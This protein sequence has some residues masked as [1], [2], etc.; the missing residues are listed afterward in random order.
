MDSPENTRKPTATGRAGDAAGDPFDPAGY[1]RAA[2]GAPV[3]LW[4]SGQDWTQ[5][6]LNRYARQRFLDAGAAEQWTW[7]EAVQQGSAARVGRQIEDAYQAGEPFCLLYTAELGGTRFV[8]AD[9]GEPRRDSAGKLAGYAGSWAVVDEP[10]RPAADD[11]SA[12]SLV[13]LLGLR[14]D[15]ASYGELITD[16]NGQV[17]AASQVMERLLGYTEQELA[18]RTLI[19]LAHAQ[20]RHSP[21]APIGPLTSRACERR[22]LKKDGGVLWS[23]TSVETIQDA[24]GQLCGYRVE[25]HDVSAEKQTER[26][27]LDS[28]QR[29]T[30]AQRAGGAGVFEWLILENRVYWSPELEELYGI[31]P[32]R[33][34]GTFDDWAKRVLPEDSEKIRQNVAEW[35]QQRRE[36][37]AYEFR[38][39]LPDGSHR[40]M[41]G[42]ARF[43][44]RE[45]GT[46]ERMIGVNVRMDLLKSVQQALEE[47]E[48][49]FR[50]LADHMSQLAWMA[51]S[52]G[53]IFWYNR[54]WYEYTGT[55]LEEMQ[56]WGWKKV[57]HPDHVDRVAEKIQKC[58][59]SGEVW[60]DTF[61]LRGRDGRY[62]WFLSRAMPMRDAQ[63]EIVRWL[64]TNT[65]IT[66]Q[67]DA[68][69]ALRE[70]DSK[71][72]E[73]L[74][75]L[76]HE[77]R[78]PLAPIRSGLD[79]LLLGVNTPEQSRALEIMRRQTSQLTRLIDDLLDVS[80]VMRGKITLQKA[81][82]EV[83]Q[84]ITQAVEACRPFLDDRRHEFRLVEHPEPIWLDADAARLAQVLGNLLNNAAK[85]TEDCGRVTLTTSAAGDKAVI[86][87]A[88]TGIGIE[89]SLLPD[90]FELFTQSTRSLDRSQGG[91]GIGLTVVEQMI[92]LHDG[93]VTV[94]SEGLGHGSTFTV[95]L[96]TIAAP[97]GVS[98]A[99]WSPDASEVSRPRKILI[100]DDNQS[101]A[102]L[103]SRLLGKLGEFEI[104]TAAD[105]PEA[106]A[107]AET[108]GPE[109]VFLDIGLPRMDGYEVA[110]RLRE[111]G[112]E[113]PAIVALSGYSR[114]ARDDPG[115]DGC[116]DRR[117][118]KPADIGALER[119]LAEL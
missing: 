94:A 17:V 70:A 15:E 54:R 10:D 118:V 100:V 7:T 66:D 11:D 31:E 109:L 113:R 88:D 112:G 93:S 38:A 116:F 101:A 119:V 12:Q 62:R 67:R 61:P 47:S 64:G 2:D 4:A 57:H 91:L 50:A 68:E 92:R 13:P 21:P 30:I 63:G 114:E 71:K 14:R 1:I 90:V 32:G 42:H 73:F 23:R 65:D 27:H 97:T 56:G 82:V 16:L 48:E 26:D 89:P 35:M 41:S 108:F 29:L 75:M 19:D 39:I 22:Y 49:R 106:L 99:S 102:Y 103:L 18:E 59:D 84:V 79:L 96:P 36:D 105:G 69:E 24:A 46:P 74:A 5:R 44:Y 81:P 78:N 111:R 76:A 55:T 45:D 6:R 115:R 72:N 58:W 83:R 3:L 40:W 33:F 8:V 77:L 85:Y 51:D 20:D 104:E 53:Y 110:R 43:F 87:V 52:E 80:R 95:T 37:C 98:A 28:L 9:R 25:V 86:E 117:L 60:E 107:A 34:G